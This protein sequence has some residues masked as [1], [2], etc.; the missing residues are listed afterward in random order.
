MFQIHTEAVTGVVGRAELLAS[1]AYLLALLSYAKSSMKQRRGQHQPATRW[2]RVARVLVWTGVSMLSKEQ[3][4]TIVGVCAAYELF[5][6]Q[7]LHLRDIFRRGTVNLAAAVKWNVVQRVLALAA[8]AVALLAARM[9]VMGAKLPVF[10][11][12]DNPAAAAEAPAKQL[13]FSY[14]I[15]QA[16]FLCTPFLYNKQ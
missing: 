9:R 6:T 3:G 11:R 14:L 16:L 13:T 2:R 7:K 8:G 12:F 15:G 4:I 1:V 5:V 10:T